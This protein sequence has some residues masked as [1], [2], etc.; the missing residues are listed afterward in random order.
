FQDGPVVLPDAN[1]SSAVGNCLRLSIIH[2][3]VAGSK[4]P[5]CVVSHQWLGSYDLGAASP[6]AK[7]GDDPCS[8]PSAPDGSDNEIKSTAQGRKLSPEAR[9][10]FDHQWVVISASDV[11]VGVLRGEF[12]NSRSAAILNR[13]DQVNRAAVFAHSINLHLSRCGWHDNGARL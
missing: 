7:P 8:G 6:R 10:A 9:V 3:D 11:S 13:V 12:S 2:H 5:S 4:R 1:R